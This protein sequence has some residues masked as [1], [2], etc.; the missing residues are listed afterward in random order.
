ME[1]A[2]QGGIE[3]F[4]DLI[5]HEIAPEPSRVLTPS[6]HRVDSPTPM[7]ET[8]P[9]SAAYEKAVFN[10]LFDN[11]ATLRISSVWRCRNSRIDGLLDLEDG[12]RLAVEVKYRMNWEK[13]C[14]TE[15]Q[16]RWFVKRVPHERPLDAAVVVFEEFSADWA[17]MSSSRLLQNGWN[18]WYME[19]H[20]VEGL[21]VDLVRYRAGVFESFWSALSS[22]QMTAS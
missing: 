17:R 9:V 20:E 16:F 1:S 8:E 14:Q 6:A 2:A 18:Y 5:N 7:T 11:M 19:H 22:A 15:A 13:A 3:P 12:R 10:A 4:S 21:R